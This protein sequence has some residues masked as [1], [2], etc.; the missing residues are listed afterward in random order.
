LYHSLLYNTP[1]NKISI[2]SLQKLRW[3]FYFSISAPGTLLLMAPFSA[4]TFGGQAANFKNSSA[5]IIDAIICITTH[6][7]RRKVAP[8]A[9]TF[10]SGEQISGAK[11]AIDWFPDRQRFYCQRKKLL[12]TLHGDL[13]ARTADRFEKSDA[14]IKAIWQRSLCCK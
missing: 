3:S 2:S 9:F 12:V 8:H 7:A 14:P 13:N 11:E 4:H 1:S 6:R 5:A 10:Q